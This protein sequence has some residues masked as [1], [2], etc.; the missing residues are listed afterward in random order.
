MHTSESTSSMRT[1]VCN[2]INT[3]SMHTS[4]CMHHIYYAYK[5][6]KIR[7]VRARKRL[8]G[9]GNSQTFRSDHII[10]NDYIVL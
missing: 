4:Y 2:S 5:L 6:C 7:F 3:R 10:I 1:V 8:V 9:M